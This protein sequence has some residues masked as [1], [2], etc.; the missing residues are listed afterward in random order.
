[1][2]DRPGPSWLMLLPGSELRALRRPEPGGDRFELLFSAACV[3]AVPKPLGQ[4]DVT[5]F[6]PDVSWLLSGVRVEGAEP[7]D[8]AFM[9]RLRDGCELLLGGQ[10]RAGLVLGPPCSG[11]PA[12]G[13]W[14][15]PQVG[16][17]LLL[18]HGESWRVSASSLEV[19]LHG[20]LAPLASL[21]C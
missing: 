10:R 7:L 20:P 12:D 17:H 16:L 2:T 6:V 11:T 13:V 18:A 9:G 3:Q 4:G 15:W 5:G 19:R 1:M 8:E 14:V 21:A